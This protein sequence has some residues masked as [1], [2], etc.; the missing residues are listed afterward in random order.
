MATEN[1]YMFAFFFFNSVALGLP[2]CT[3]AFSS[4][5]EW[6][7]LFVMVP[8][9][10][11]AMISLVEEHGPWSTWASCMWAHGVWAQ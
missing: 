7:L 8:R 3:Q 4:C 2:C 10:P 1:K 9:L 5:R 6:G 11:I